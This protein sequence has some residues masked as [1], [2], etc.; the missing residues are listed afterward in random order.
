MKNL[1]QGSLEIRLIIQLL[2]WARNVRIIL[3]HANVHWNVVT[4]EKKK[5]QNNQVHKIT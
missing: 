5:S 3:A 1:K 4:T 2:E